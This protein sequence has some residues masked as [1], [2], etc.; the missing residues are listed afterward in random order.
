MAQFKKILLAT[1]FS[2]C[3]AHAQAYAF[4]FAKRFDAEVHVVHAV[5]TAYPSYAGVYGFGV[6]VERHIGAVKQQ[7]QNDLG[8]IIGKANEAGIHAHA[9]VL[10]GRPSDAVVD[11]AQSLG[12]DLLITGTHGRSGLDHFLFG[13]TA[14]R[15]VRQSPVPVLAVKPHE[16]DFVKDS[17]A[18]TLKRVLCPVDL[19]PLADQAVAHAADICRVFGAELLIM[20]IVDSR[21]EYPLVLPDIQIAPPEEFRRRAT[22]RLKELAAQQTGV[23]VD[24]A[25]LEGVP[26]KAINEQATLYKADLLIMTTHGYGGLSRA[27]LGS[28]AEKLVRT[29][30]VPTLTIKPSE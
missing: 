4:A 22:E 6:D 7:A 12:C 10:G 18:F 30:P 11:K 19:S 9:H 28:T 1:D 20:H 26:H 17:G 3:A 25:V 8:A 21:I 5:D 15:I 27:L 23:K 24:I 14:E 16:R 29:A 13:S 2:D